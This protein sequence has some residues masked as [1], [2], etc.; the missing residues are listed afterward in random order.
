MASVIVADATAR[1]RRARG[2]PSAGELAWLTFAGFVALFGVW[3][4]WPRPAGCPSSS[5]RRRAMLR[6]RSCN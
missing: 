1:A 2:E 3:W 6:R 5:C 4:G